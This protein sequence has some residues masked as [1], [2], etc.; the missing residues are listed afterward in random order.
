VIKEIRMIRKGFCMICGRRLDADPDRPNDGE[1]HDDCKRHNVPNILKNL[2]V[3]KE[4]RVKILNDQGVLTTDK[5]WDCECLTNFIHPKSQKT[6]FKCCTR[7]D[8]QPDS[9]VSEVLAEGYLL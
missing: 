7:A 3:S 6:C 1:Q 4:G 5:F 9:R 8:E 2:G